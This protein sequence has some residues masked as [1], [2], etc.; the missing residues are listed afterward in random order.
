MKYNIHKIDSPLSQKIALI[1]I[2]NDQ[3]HSISITNFG[4]IVHAWQCP[5][6]SGN[7]ADI[8]LGC[9]NILDYQNSHPYFGA[10]IGR[11][12]NRIAFG[13][14]KINETEYILATN[15]SDHHLHGGNVGFDK[16]IWDF[17]I[18]ETHDNIAIIF[19]YKSKHMEEG[20][21]GNLNVQ[22]TYTFDFESKL[23]IEYRASTD[24]A[25][26]LNLTNHCY[27]NL[28][29]DATSTILD[30]QLQI[31]AETITESDQSLIPT[32][33]II[34]IKGSNFDF[35]E[36]TEIGLRI[37]ND[38]PQLIN[39]NG[40][41]HNYI[42]NES[43]ISK[44]VAEVLHPS[45]GRRLKVFTT[46]PGI[47]LYTGNWLADVEGKPGKYCNYAGFCLETQ[48]FPDSPNHPNFPSTML[49]PDC[50]YYS[51]TIYKMDI[52]TT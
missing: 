41:D 15:G 29:G 31:Q 47:Q 17:D 12:A 22:V 8:L 14:F 40:Y 26:H 20:Y 19:T 42:L 24:E 38:D 37:K 52:K 50:I 30:H 23:T 4:G 6:R 21:P 35:K 44:A 49:L 13:K 48:H 25:T 9:K 5:D 36:M 2:S 33:R 10:I 43:N 3:N 34:D 32:G 1:T 46:E 28:S 45:T 11:Y 51:K 7:I 39:A 16:K 27:F 18:K